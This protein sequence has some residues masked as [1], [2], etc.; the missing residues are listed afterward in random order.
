MQLCAELPRGRCLHE[1]GARGGARVA[2]RGLAR[3]VAHSQARRR[4]LP[5]TS[6]RSHQQVLRW[7]VARQDFR[8]PRTRGPLFRPSVGLM[9]AP[10]PRPNMLGHAFRRK[11]PPRM[12]QIWP[13]SR[14]IQPNSALARPNLA[15]ICLPPC[16]TLVIMG[17]WPT[18]GP[19]NWLYSADI[20]L[21]LAEFGQSWARFDRVR[22]KFAPTWVKFDPAWMDFEGRLPNSAQTRSI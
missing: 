1:R 8:A 19:W 13:K 15:Q 17:V 6:G 7:H 3:G 22:A 16:Q 4:S 12:V 11:S 21:T 5:P 14:Q 2:C 18:P 9:R 10:D 20:S